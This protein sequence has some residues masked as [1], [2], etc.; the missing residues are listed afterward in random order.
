[1]KEI[2]RKKQIYFI[3]LGGLIILV[4]LIGGIVFPLFKKVKKSGE[5]IKNQK[6]LLALMGE[7]KGYYF[8]LSND[9]ETLKNEFENIPT[10]F[11]EP[12]PTKAVHFVELLEGIA[13]NNNLELEFEGFSEGEGLPKKDMK[14]IKAAVSHFLKAKATVE[15]EEEKKDSKKED[16]KKKEM[17]PYLIYTIRLQGEFVDIVKFLIHL[18]NLQYHTQ[19]DSMKMKV[20]KITES[21]VRAEKVESEEAVKG[22][23]EAIEGEE[24]VEDKED[25]EDK[26]GEEREEVTPLTIE[27]I[28]A[29]IEGR[30]YL[31]PTLVSS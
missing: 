23:E 29:E 28:E 3:L 18:E 17:L 6:A 11:L 13:R 20:I 27:T 22:E 1:M 31:D 4:I 12:E 2:S 24:G 8:Q 30:V 14:E 26:K 15:L 10:P 19:V 5:E 21:E 25:E 9:F 16:K 7:Q